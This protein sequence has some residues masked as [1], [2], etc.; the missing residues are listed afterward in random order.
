MD[1]TTT[2]H[3]TAAILTVK[4]RVDALTAGDLE[5]AINTIIDK[6][7]RCIILDFSGLTYISSGGLRVLLATAKKLQ[8]NGDR[9]MLCGLS[10]DVQKVMN[11]AGFTAIFSIYSSASEALDAVKKPVKP[12]S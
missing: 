11:L 9:F 12:H 7:D 1:I 10:I 5:S 6:G 4:G 8:N 2:T 3:D